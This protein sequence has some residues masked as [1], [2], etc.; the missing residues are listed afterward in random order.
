MVAG[1]TF[2]PMGDLSDSRIEPTSSPLAGSFFTH[3]AIREAFLMTIYHCK[4]PV[5]IQGLFSHV[6]KIITLLYVDFTVRSPPPPPPP[7]LVTAF[8][9]QAA[10]TVFSGDRSTSVSN[11]LPLYSEVTLLWIHQGPLLPSPASFPGICF[12]QWAIWLFFPYTE[13]KVRKI[14][15]KHEE[16]MQP[17]EAITFD[18]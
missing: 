8:S 11:I 18:L 10:S 14:K 2:P 4:D 17:E 5:F 6:N 16:K 7:P 13:L 1:M 3:W 9:S 12:P 15:G